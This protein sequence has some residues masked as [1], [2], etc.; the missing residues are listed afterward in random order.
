MQRQ[1]KA[2]EEWRVEE[3]GKIRKVVQALIIGVI[4]IAIGAG[5]GIW[6]VQN[7]TEDNRRLSQ[8]TATLSETNA[9]LINRVDDLNRRQAEQ[10]YTEC[11][12][13]NQRAE[14]SGAALSLLAQANLKDGNKASAAVWQKYLDAANKNKLPPCI[15]PP[16]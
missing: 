14:A 3:E 15:K 10:A 13:R 6:R 5:G 11:L 9:S 1:L 7:L 16:K 4:L 2:L 8:S 12:D